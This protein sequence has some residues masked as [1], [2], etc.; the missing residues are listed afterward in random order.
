M[1]RLASSPFIAVSV[2]YTLLCILLLLFCLGIT[3]EMFLISSYKECPHSSS[4]WTVYSIECCNL[5]KWAHIGGR[6]GCFP[7]L[8]FKQHCDKYIVHIPFCMCVTMFVGKLPEVECL[9][10][11]CVFVLFW[12]E[13]HSYTAHL[14][15]GR[16][17]LICCQQG[18][19]GPMLVIYKVCNSYCLTNQ[20]DVVASHNNNPFLSSTVSVSAGEGW[21]GCA[22]PTW[23]LSG[24]CTQ[25]VA[26]AGL[27][28]NTFSVT[29][30]MQDWRELESPGD[31]ITGTTQAS[32]SV[33]L[34]STPACW[35]Q[36]SQTSLEISKR[37]AQGTRFKEVF[38]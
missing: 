29:R 12:L 35:H 2:L 16:T 23:A 8:V 20:S 21:L 38:F 19:R 17:N 6:L 27:T 14:Q 30:L 5:L 15:G 4:A 32:L 37:S 13:I 26:G 11:G 3:P 28:L 24:S 31:G 18:T 9:G 34:W 22:V 1:N 7:L 25:I 33:L 10:K 36:G